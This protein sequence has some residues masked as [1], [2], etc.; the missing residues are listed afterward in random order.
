[1]R[2]NCPM[3]MAYLMARLPGTKLI[4]TPVPCPDPQITVAPTTQPFLHLDHASNFFAEVV[5]HPASRMQT[6]LRAR[7]ALDRAWRKRGP[8]SAALS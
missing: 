3:M 6:E 7:I 5:S 2:H 8:P 1:M 4:P